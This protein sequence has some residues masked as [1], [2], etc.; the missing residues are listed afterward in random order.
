MGQV[1]WPVFESVTQERE[2][3]ELT[4]GENMAA[5]YKLQKTAKNMRTKGKKGKYC[6]F[7]EGR[8]KKNGKFLKLATHEVSSW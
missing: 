2:V 7:Q 5:N 8:Q 1:G 3:F 4:I 6:S